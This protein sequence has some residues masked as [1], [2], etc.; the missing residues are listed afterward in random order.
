MLLVCQVAYS[1]MTCFHLLCQLKL[2]AVLR[3][4]IKIRRLPPVYEIA[5]A[6]FPDPSSPNYRLANG[7]VRR[8]ALAY[9]HVAAGAFG[10]QEAEL[11]MVLLRTLTDCQRPRRR[12]RSQW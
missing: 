12:A 8:V 4:S 1:E 11:G 6:R 3:I 9:T 2:L 10:P 5:R 7:G